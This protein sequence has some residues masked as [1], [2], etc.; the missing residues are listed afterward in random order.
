MSRAKHSSMP[1]ADFAIGWICASAH[2]LSASRAMLDKEFGAPEDQDP[3]DD[4]IYVLGQIAGHNVVLASLAAGKYGNEPAVTV[5]KDM[6]RTFTSMKFGLLVGIG[7]GVP[8]R[9]A[10]IRLGD[11]VVSKPSKSNGGVIQYDMGKVLPNG[12]FE[13]RG[14]LNKPPDALLKAVQ[15]LSS[16]HEMEGSNLDRHLEGAFSKYPKMRKPYSCPG[17]A[18]DRLYAADKTC[19]HTDDVESCEACQNHKVVERTQRLDE[20]GNPD[21]TPYIHYGLIGSGSSVIASADQRDRLYRDA[22]ILCFEMEAAGLM[23]AFPCLVIRG[24]SDYADSSKEDTWQRYAAATA[25]AYAKELISVLPVQRVG[26]TLSAA[27]TM[28]Q[29]SPSGT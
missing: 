18:L 11:V 17:R 10:D 13:R 6:L 29:A 5:A 21:E 25:A 20:N 4:N 16:Q 19:G 26:D 2:E 1:N 7:G 23:D 28:R 8:S 22:E 24:I 14:I 15:K 27:T 3:H 9:S 12:A